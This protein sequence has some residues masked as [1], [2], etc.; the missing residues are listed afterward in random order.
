MSDQ[1]TQVIFN[2]AAGREQDRDDLLERLGRLGTVHTTKGPGDARRLARDAAAGGAGLVVAAGGDGTVN[3]VVS[4]LAPGFEAALAV[5]P[6]GTGNDLAGTLGMPDD[7]LEAVAVVAAGPTVAADVIRLRIAGEERWAV[8][9]VTAGFSAL[10]DEAL[11]SRSKELL[12]SLAYLVTAGRSL[13]E[14]EAH[15]L[16]LSVDD[17]DERSLDA[18]N[19]VLANGPTVG[20]GVPVAADARLDDGLLHLLVV[21]EMPLPALAVALGRLFAVGGGE[22][23]ELHVERVRKVRFDAEPAMQVTADGE[24]VGRTPA[25]AEVLPGA[26]R[27]VIGRPPAG[28]A[29]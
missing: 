3:E 5:V 10:V 23:R 1:P 20:G 18:F 25:Q 9:A 7:P 14:L 28:A 21:P 24:V 16:R 17:G 19:L 22:V 12:G 2:P 11:E 8:N 26:L 6:L 27:C 29:G 4:G 15:R 13:P